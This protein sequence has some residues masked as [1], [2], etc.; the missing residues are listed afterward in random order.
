M[1][2][3]FGPR[4]ARQAERALL[5][6]GVLPRT[7]LVEEV[8]QE[9][10]CRLLEGDGRRLAACRAVNEGQ[11][12]N[13]LGRVVE[14]VILDQVRMRRAAKRGGGRLQLFSGLDEKR[15]G[16]WLADPAASPE[17]RLL[18]AERRQLLLARWRQVSDGPQGPRDLRI[19]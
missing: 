8:V 13:Y 5:Q 2:G 3:R 16:R 10:Y 12:T 14:R 15:L 6:V 17:D 1:V 4:L 9:V 7:D 19:L 11:A 18:A